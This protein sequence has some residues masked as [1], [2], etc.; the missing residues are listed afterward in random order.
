MRNLK[1]LGLAL[2]AMFAMSAVTAGAASADH[3]TAEQYPATLTG[4]NTTE[5]DKFLTTTG[6]VNC[7]TASYAA[8]ISA[9]ATSVSATPTYS[10]CTAFG[11]P[12]T[13]DVNG[14]KYVFNIGAGT[15]GDADL[16]CEAGKTIT[17]TAVSAG[18]IKCTVHV[19][20]QSDIAGTITYSNTGAGTTREVGIV[21]SLSG[22][23]YSHTKGTGLGACP[24]GSATNGTLEASGDVTAETDPIPP[25]MPVHQGFFLSF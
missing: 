6:T 20:S 13:I 16:S 23:D 15:T 19:A 2:M 14:C 21:V 25:T 12:A 10:N 4:K 22:I 9:A 5:T 11:F 18:T 1:I 8:T 3:I 7:K 24:A 17:V